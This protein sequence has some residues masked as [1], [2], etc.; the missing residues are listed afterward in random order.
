MKMVSV[1]TTKHVTDENVWLQLQYL[2]MIIMYDAYSRYGNAQ[3]KNM[4]FNPKKIITFPTSNDSTQQKPHQPTQQKNKNM[5]QTFNTRRTYLSFPFRGKFDPFQRHRFND[6]VCSAHLSSNQRHR[7]EKVV[8]GLFEGRIA[9]K[10][11]RLEKKCFCVN[12]YIYILLH[13]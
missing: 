5:L 12:I 1:C 8:G 2:N 9:G 6:A 11:N 4:A 7:P 13:M 3:Q 10:K